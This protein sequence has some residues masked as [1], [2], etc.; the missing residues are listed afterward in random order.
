MLIMKMTLLKLYHAF[1]ASIIL[2]SLSAFIAPLRK[3]VSDELSFF[4][5]LTMA[6]LID[7]VIGIIKYWKLSQFSFREM[8]TGLI[9]KVAVA[10]GG[11]L[12]FLS[13]QSLDPGIAADWFGLLAKFT[14]LVYPAGSA[15]ANMY[16]ITAGR[17]PPIA[18]MKKLKDFD[19]IS[20]ST[21][22][23]IEDKQKVNY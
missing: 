12:I 2:T 8:V 22:S 20:S 13:F 21:V 15:F 5:V 18:F 19:Q 9:I 11:M 6:L 1:L 14:V 3:L 7:L 17:F 10:Y 4:S 16:V 23:V